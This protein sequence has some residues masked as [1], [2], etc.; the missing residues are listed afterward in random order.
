[1]NNLVFKYVLE[2]LP[3][4]VVVQF[5]KIVK[6]NHY[7]SNVYLNYNSKELYGEED[8]NES[9]ILLDKL[10]QV[11]RYNLSDILLEEM[12]ESIQNFKIRSEVDSFFDNVCA[13]L[14]NQQNFENY[15][16]RNEE[17]WKQQEVYD[18]WYSEY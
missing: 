3:Q 18:I 6:D 2:I 15:L 10:L 11:A 13:E 14:E 9:Q 7:L 5:Y 8:N 4:F 1:M 12:D 16:E 17:G